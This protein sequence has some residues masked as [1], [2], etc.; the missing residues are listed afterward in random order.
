MK[1]HSVIR[2]QWGAGEPCKLLLGTLGFQMQMY[3]T[4]R[5]GGFL[6]GE[7]FRCPCSLGSGGQEA[8]CVL[9]KAGAPG[10]GQGPGENS[11]VSAPA[12]PA[13]GTVLGQQEGSWEHGCSLRGAKLG[14]VFITGREAGRK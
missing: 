7:N 11:R 10:A 6:W 4:V 12:V 14:V 3:A 9:T 5:G 2:G 13:S 1:S 8:C